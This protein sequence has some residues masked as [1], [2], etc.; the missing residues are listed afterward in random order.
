MDEGL[1]QFPDGER[2]GFENALGELVDRAQRVLTAQGRLRSLIEANQAVVEDL[3][4]EHV[5]RRIVEAAVTLVDAQYGAVG[6]IDSDRHLERFIHIGIPADR[7]LEIG[8]L[9][10]GHGLLGAVIDSEAAIRLE[11]LSEDPRSVGFPAHHPAMDSFLGVPI[12]VRNVVFGN[13]YLANRGDG[14]FTVEDQELV[15]ALAA[16][17]GIA[18]D[19]A[20]LYEES[21]R[22]QR[23]ST[24]LAEVTS[25]LLSPGTEDVL[26]VVAERVA[27]IVPAELV[28]IVAPGSSAGELHV[29]AARGIGANAVEGV[30]FAADGSLAARAIATG[31]IAASPRGTERAS[32]AGE[33]A[34]GP[35]VAVPLIVSGR[36]RGALCVARGAA[37]P[38]FSAAELATLSEFALQAGLA[39]ALARA[40]LDRQR[41]DVIEDRGRIARDLH[42]HVIQRLFGTGLGLQSLIA[43]DPAHAEAIARHVAEIDAAIGDIRTA[44]FT[45]KSGSISD[46]TRVRHRLLDVVAELTPSLA[47]PPRITFAGPVDLMLTGD[48]ADDVVAVVRETLANVAR[49]ARAGTTVVDVAVSD[50]AVTVTVDDDGIGLDP[51]STRSSGTA[52]LAARAE[53]HG[54]TFALERSPAGGTRARWHAPLSPRTGAPR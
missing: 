28:T 27:S 7:A 48:L 51:A 22:R 45:L 44:V 14:P 49:H 39:I 12:R 32:P 37:D 54:G 42:D 34:L 13:L 29:D 38:V 10:E 36:P 19:N 2:S 33:R 31:Q 17:A 18:I 41:L 47:A 43:A 30:V 40:R 21:Q 52:N 1:L 53:G 25:A 16:T 24:A 15:T 50:L 26:G 8:R 9:P 35:V 6:V 20:R 46:A 4:L 5:L 3:E 11:H 23:L